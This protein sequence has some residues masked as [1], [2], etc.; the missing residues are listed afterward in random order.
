MDVTDEKTE[1]KKELRSFGLVLAAIITVIFGAILPW[2][3]SFSFPMWPWMVSGIIALLAI[4]YPICLAPVHWLLLRI[5]VPLGRF[6]SVLI[7]SL[8]YF[9]LVCPMGLMMRLF[10]RD[11]IQRGFDEKAK[12]YRKE[13]EPSSSL[14]VPF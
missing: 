2:L 9:V 3:F 1:A 4:V 10:R 7:L 12:T 14:E 8:V 5:A 13:S 11:P 6:N